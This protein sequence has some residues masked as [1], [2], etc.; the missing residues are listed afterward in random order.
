MVHWGEEIQRLNEGWGATSCCYLNHTLR[1]SFYLANLCLVKRKQ[2][3]DERKYLATME[4]THKKCR[5]R[6]TNIFKH[7][8]N[9][10][11]T[12]WLAVKHPLG[13]LQ[14]CL[15]WLV[16][17]MDSEFDGSLVEQGHHGHHLSKRMNLTSILCWSRDT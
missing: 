11:L 7:L 12:E 8:H 6:I 10:I 1:V 17:E 13:N 3:N 14:D 4:S 15:Q 16:F 5:H 9:D 2:K